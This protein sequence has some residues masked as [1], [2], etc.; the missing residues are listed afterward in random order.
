MKFLVSGSAGFI[1]YHLCKSLLEDRHEVLGIDNINNY[2]DQQLKKDRLELLKSYNNFLFHKTDIVDKDAISKIFK[3]FL[4]QKVINL[5]A[6]PGVHHSIKEPDSYIKDNISGFLNIIDLSKNFNVESFV[7]ASSS[8]VYGSRSEIPFNISRSVKTPDSFY[9]I[10]KITNELIAHSYSNLYKLK[11]TGLRYF[12][13]YGPWCR[14][15]MAMFIFIDKMIKKQPLKVFDNGN[16]KRDF[17]YIDD[18]IAGTRSAINRNY[19][20]EIFNLGNGKS[21]DLNEIISFFEKELCIKA[22]IDYKPIQLGDISETCADINYSK[23]KI[24]YKPQTSIDIGIAKLIKWYR[25][26][27]NV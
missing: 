4:P 25:N 23:K 1:G 18:I 21:Y 5:A 26:Y 15:D 16:I 19:R 9:G 2:Y 17:T 14:P 13:V 12:T 20:C 6:Q 24:D 11:T 3:A 7:Y 22:K 27:Y 10:T 8:S